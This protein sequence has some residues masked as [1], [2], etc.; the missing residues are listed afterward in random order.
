[1]DAS[2]LFRA[3]SEQVQLYADLA[4]NINGT[5]LS[6]VDRGTALPY[7]VID[8]LPGDTDYTFQGKSTIESPLVRMSIYSEVANGQE[9]AQLTKYLHECFDNARLVFVE[10]GY[11]CMGCERVGSYPIRESE[12]IWHMITEYKITFEKT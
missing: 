7:L 3:I 5:F 9:F 11:H 6:M 2:A 8:L 4:D 12:K 10:G 1:M